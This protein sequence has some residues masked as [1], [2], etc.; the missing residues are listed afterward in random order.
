MYAEELLEGRHTM[1]DRKSDP[2]TLSRR[3][4]LSILGLATVAAYAAPAALNL[5]SAK[6]KTGY[7]TRTRTRT[8]TR[9]HP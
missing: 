1:T 4:A 3:K 8:R 9:T 5:S 2:K 7:Q 6:A